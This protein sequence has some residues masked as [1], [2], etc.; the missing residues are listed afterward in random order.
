MRIGI[1]LGPFPVVSEKFILNQIASLLD[2]GIDVEILTSELRKN[3]HTHSIVQSYRLLERTTEVSVPSKIAN[4]FLSLPRMLPRI[5][6]L[7]PLYTLRAFH[8]RYTTASRNLK[9]FY[10]LAG[11]VNRTFDILHCHFGQNGLIGAYNPS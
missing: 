3:T 6:F 2:R 4:R 5:L 8:P 1:L 9:T 10:F 7:H 11:C